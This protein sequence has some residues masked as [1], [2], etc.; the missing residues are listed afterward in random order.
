M[1]QVT[2]RIPEVQTMPSI[3]EVQDSLAQVFA[4]TILVHAVELIDTKENA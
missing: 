4:G 1:I 2:F 3:T